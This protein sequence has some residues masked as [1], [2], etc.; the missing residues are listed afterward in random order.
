MFTLRSDSRTREKFTKKKKN[1]GRLEVLASPFQPPIPSPPRFSGAQ[2]NSL[3]TY[4]RAL[5]S[6]RLEQA[7]E[8]EEIKMETF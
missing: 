8:K 5:L 7:G 1:K 2:L 3:P 4:R 6:E